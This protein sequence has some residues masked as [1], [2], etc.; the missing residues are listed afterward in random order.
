MMVDNATNSTTK[1]SWTEVKPLATM[2]RN[3]TQQHEWSI[4]HI[5]GTG[6]NNHN[7][8]FVKVD[9]NVLFDHAFYI[10]LNLIILDRRDLSLVVNK[11]YSTWKSEPKPDSDFID[12]FYYAHEMAKEIKKYNYAYFVIVTSQFMWEPFFS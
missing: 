9:D 10:G 2:M 6:L 11:N 5:R 3:N 12:D 4:L 8:S 1:T 7:S